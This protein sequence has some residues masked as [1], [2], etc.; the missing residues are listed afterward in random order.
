VYADASYGQK[1]GFLRAP[2]G[3][4][5]TFDVPASGN[6]PLANAGPV[7]INN[8]GAITGVYLADFP[9]HHGFLRAPDGIFTTFDVPGGILRGVTA[10]NAAGA[11]VGFYADDV[12]N[13]GFVRAPDGTFSTFGVPGSVYTLPPFSI[14]DAGVIAG[15]FYGSECCITGGH[16]FLFFSSTPSQM[17]SNL[18]T[19]VMGFNLVQ[20]I[21]S[22]L[23]AKLGA[24]AA[25]LIAARANDTGTAC[26]QMGAFINAVQAQSGKVLTVAQANQLVAAANQIK[27]VL[28]CP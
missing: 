18:T 1:H 9:D 19:T 20:G 21:A 3:T 4:I 6:P 26:N 5:T 16:G 24:A 25:A 14:N 27:A 28:G 8:A 7:G 12:N 13:R 17:I 22:S 2:D 15:S 23:D 10:I 11:I